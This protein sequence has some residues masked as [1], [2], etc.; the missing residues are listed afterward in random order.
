ML[1]AVAFSAGL[2]DRS[3]SERAL[4][5]ALGGRTVR[6]LEALEP[7]E[8]EA[9]AESIVL[10]Q[11]RQAEALAAAADGTLDHIPRFARGVIRKLVTRR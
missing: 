7:A 10:A 3:T 11:R 8:L 1:P 2:E 9:L 6:G 5:D 4:R